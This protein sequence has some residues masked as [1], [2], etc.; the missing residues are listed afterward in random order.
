[1]ATVAEATVFCNNVDF[2]SV[3]GSGEDTSFSAFSQLPRPLSNPM[4]N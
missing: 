1:M 2:V 3:Q 4:E